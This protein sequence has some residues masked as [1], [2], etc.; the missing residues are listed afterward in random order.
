MGESYSI[1]VDSRD[2][3]TTIRLT[4]EIDIAAGRDVRAAIADSILGDPLDRLVI[5]LTD[6]TF[7]D[8]TGINALVLARHAARFAAAVLEVTAGPPSVMRVLELS[9]LQRFLNV[10]PALER[11]P[12][13]G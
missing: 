10:R 7:L 11:L 13:A 6:T 1:R 3:T 9:G 5:D 4:G 12:S 8:S 2:G